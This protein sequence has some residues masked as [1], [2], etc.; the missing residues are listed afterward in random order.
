MA[1]NDFLKSA[2]KTSTRFIMTISDGRGNVINH[3]TVSKLKSLI[4]RK[5]TSPIKEIRM[6][7]P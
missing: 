4:R 5:N 3:K 6:K 7:Q 2:E 1:E